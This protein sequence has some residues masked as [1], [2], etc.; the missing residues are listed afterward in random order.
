MFLGCASLWRDGRRELEVSTLLV[1]DPPASD[2]GDEPCWHGTVWGEGVESLD[3]VTSHWT[4]RVGVRA[5]VDADVAVLRDSI[6][7][8]ALVRG[9]GPAPFGCFGS[10]TAARE[11]VSP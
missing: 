1:Q 9:R 10:V 6:P 4:L 8:T 5:G 7:P 11:Q 2:D 3:D